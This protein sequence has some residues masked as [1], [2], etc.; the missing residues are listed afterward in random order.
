MDADTTA[1]L[2]LCSRFSRM[3]D[4]V[5]VLEQREYHRLLDWLS[6]QGMN[7]RDLL[8]EGAPLEAPDLPIPGERLAAL[9]E[10]GGIM[11]V[12]VEGWESRGL[13]VISRFDESYPARLRSLDA[14]APPV[15]YGAGDPS[16]FEPP[17]HALAI[18][19][20]RDVDER[21][22]EFA[23]DLARACARQQVQVVS[24]AARGVDSLAMGAA[25]EAGGTVVGVVADSL[26]RVATSGGNQGPLMEGQL[27]LV[28]PYDPAAGFNVGNAM[29]RNKYIYALADAAAVVQTS[30]GTGG[31]WNGAVE[32]LKRGSPPVYTRVEEGVPAGNIKLLELGAHAF[33]EEVMDDLRAWLEQ[34]VDVDEEL[35]QG[36]LL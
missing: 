1:T 13:W 29:G 21:G 30:E 36:Q 3:K 12:A 14:A 32:A 8:G 24:G 5:P 18:V 16:L 28:S 33:T 19:G 34:S 35:V 17:A 11:A 26:Q 31:T 15:L 2:L 22:A 10:R 23:A 6:S 7:P 20:S 9:L 4:A 25:L 27:L